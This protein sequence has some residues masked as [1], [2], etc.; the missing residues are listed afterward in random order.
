MRV[1]LEWLQDYV[2]VD[3]PP[4]VIA[5]QLAGVGLGVEAVDRAGEDVVLDLE[6]TSNRPDWMSLLGV[7]REAAVLLKRPVRY[8]RGYAGRSTRLDRRAVG[9]RSARAAAASKGAGTGATAADLAQVEVQDPAGCPRFTATVIEGV[10]VGASPEWM[11]RRLESAGV[12]AINNVVDVTNYVML[13]TGQPMHAFD[14][15]KV[16]GRRL[17]VRRARR[18]ET[19]ETLDEITRTLDDT[20]LVVAD[21][22]RAVSVAGVIGGRDTEIGLATTRVLL[23]A[24]YWDP[25]TI[26][27]TARRLGIRTEAGARFERG[28]DPNGPPRAQARAA[29][30]LAEACGGRVLPGIV[31]VYPRPVR[32]RTIRLRPERAVAVLGVRISP[33]EMARILRALG[34]GVTPGR[35][36]AVQAP[37]F[38]PDLLREEDLIEEVIRVYGYDRVPLTLPRG[39]TT[40]GVRAPALVADGRVREVLTRCGLVEALTLTLVRA[41]AEGPGGPPLAGLANPLTQDHNAL[42]R[43]LVPGLV[44]VLATNAAQRIADVQV[45]EIG[46]V[47][48]P[49]GGGGVEERR[50]LG[51]AGMGRWRAGW[52]VPADAVAVDVYHLRWVLDTLLGDLGIRGWE[53]AAPGDPVSPA[54]AGVAD[55]RPDQAPPNAPDWRH[56]GRSA[57]VRAAGRVVARFGELHPER[58]AGHRLPHRA[59]VAEVDLEALYALASGRGAGDRVSDTIPPDGLPPAPPIAPVGLFAGLPRYPEVE[60]DLAAVV[61]DEV[62]AGRVAAVIREAGGPLLEGIELFDVYTGPPVPVGHRNLAYRLRLRAPDRTLVASEAEEILRQIRIALTGRAN[63]QLRE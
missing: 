11:R 19:L 18:G 43:S 42:R 29:V 16:A 9:A 56:P 57:E 24:A 60:R 50:S 53:V 30:L 20:M 2:A 21:A 40:P 12:R 7:A 28:A 39:D 58:A 34:C 38:R 6:I 55:H 47:F 54:S 4:E 41:A 22:A 27:R 26:A 17:V 36:L 33:R 8:P 61:P 14:Y 32:P 49:R 3:G 46:R 62:P 13:E 23:E 44:K 10:R 25:P 63:A 15:D 48:L 5:E 1:P 59:C 45:F 37:T 35:V 31:D 52:N 51:I